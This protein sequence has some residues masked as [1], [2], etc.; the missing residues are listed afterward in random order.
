MK[1]GKIGILISIGL[2]LAVVIIIGIVWY[3]QNGPGSI[4]PPTEAT[5]ADGALDKI[6]L[7]V[8]P[9]QLVAMPGSGKGA[10]AV[11]AD[12]IATAIGTGDWQDFP[13]FMQKINT[14]AKPLD[15]PQFAKILDQLQDA[16]TKPIAD[17]DLVFS[18]LTINPINDFGSRYI[19]YGIA[20]MAGNA[21]RQCRDAG[22]KAKAQK[23][24]EAAYIFGF[25]LWDKGPYRAY[26]KGGLDAMSEAAVS[27]A[28]LL[29]GDPKE[30]L[31]KKIDSDIEAAA[32]K[33]EDKEKK[34]I[35][36]VAPEPG[37]MKNLALNDKDRAWRTEGLM[38]LAVAKYTT[39]VGAER[40]AIDRFLDEQSHSSDKLY[41]ATAA[42][43]AKFTDVDTRQIPPS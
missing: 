30:A 17:D 36:S 35:R 14:T 42:A 40:R 15:D 31:A 22:D 10:E 39:A 24:L 12:M 13:N 33:W 16:A 29:A 27:L 3:I 23:I 18:Q 34:T 9:A 7:S 43:A 20:K 25:R 2:V 5:T 21:A 19:L 11:Y 41:A 8:D 32:A 1:S 6:L 38:W 26:R 28:S 37:D 4:R